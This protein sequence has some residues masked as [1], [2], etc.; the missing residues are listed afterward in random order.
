MA[1]FEKAWPIILDLEG[2][3]Y[4]NDPADPGGPTKFGLT[5]KFINL[6]TL[7]NPWT[8]DRLK[9]MDE[10]TAEDMYN[11]FLWIPYRMDEIDDQSVANK[12][13]AMIVNLGV[14]RAAR[15]VQKA[16]KAELPWLGI[17]IDGVIGSKTLHVIN[18]TPANI[19]LRTIKSMLWEYYETWINAKLER[20]KYRKGLYRRAML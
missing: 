16:I 12:I 13:F 6:H 10:K 19:L 8:I 14:L 18:T 1:D 15:I 2:S 11:H 17:K 3:K 4:T 20:E 9:L 5:L 7:E